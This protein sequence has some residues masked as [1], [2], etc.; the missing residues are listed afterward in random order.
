MVSL[1]LIMFLQISA[2]LVDLLNPSYPLESLP[3]AD[4]VEELHPPGQPPRGVC[5]RH[6][7]ADTDRLFLRR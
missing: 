5:R 6:G 2:E 1:I 7:K 4:G 3:E